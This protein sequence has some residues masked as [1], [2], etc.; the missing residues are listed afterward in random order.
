MT[1]DPAADPVLHPSLPPELALPVCPM[2]AIREPQVADLVRLFWRVR[3]YGVLPV[4]GG[5]DDQPA[6]VLD[7]FDEMAG[8]IADVQAWALTRKAGL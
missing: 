5:L 2:R 7:A 1:E 6:R 8:A 3:R 4:A